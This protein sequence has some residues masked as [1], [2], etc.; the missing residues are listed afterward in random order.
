VRVVSVAVL[1]VAAASVPSV[2]G[3][4]AQTPAGTG[5]PPAGT[6]INTPAAYANPLCEKNAGPY[7]KLKFVR[8]DGFPDRG[9]SPVCVAVWNGNSNGGATHQ[10]VTKDSIKIVALVPNEQQIAAAPAQ[11]RPTKN[12]IG[13]QGSGTMPD[14]LSDAF[15]AY[16]HAYETYGRKVE[17]EFVV[18]TGDDESAQRADAVTVKTKK[19]FA[20]IDATW[21][22]H[23]VFETLVAAAKILV[24]GTGSAATYESTQKQAPYRW[25]QADN[26]AVALNVAEFVGKQLAGKRAQYAGD[27]AMHDQSRKFG[28]VYPTGVFDPELFNKALAKYGI[29]TTS[30]T[31]ITYPAPAGV[32]GDPTLA[33]E[34]APTAIT[35]LKAAGVTSVVLMADRAMITE[36]LKAATAQD[37]HPEWIITG[38]QYSD[39]GLF[40]RGYD[41]DQWAHAFGISPLPA[42]FEVGGSVATGDPTLEPVQWYFG[43]GKGTTNVQVMNTAVNWLMSGI[44]YAGPK[45]TPQMFKQ[46]YFSI[47]AQGG[48][49]DNDPL[50]VQSGYGR[51]AGLPY[52]EYLRGTQDFT[53]VWWDPNTSGRPATGGASPKGTYFYVDGGAR[54]AANRWPTK[55]VKFF[56]KSTSA[57]WEQLPPAPTPQRAPCSDCPSATGQGEPPSGA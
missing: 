12:A 8:T 3:N 44:M 7:G 30:G 26:M 27:N 52:D 43:T 36:L 20:V 37:F 39:L 42:G 29:K 57:D 54:Y 50:S 5:R 49:A 51:T 25:G 38:Y 40:A 23:D 14:A 19:P 34:Q 48:A 15:A 17:L 35:K 45:L 53:T 46:G 11:G 10:G 2:A 28:V 47:P 21:A 22:T 13:T 18:S 4:A 24:Y 1:A 9:G 31:T 33:Q 6:G 56:D 55:P 32:T 41:Q 16:Q